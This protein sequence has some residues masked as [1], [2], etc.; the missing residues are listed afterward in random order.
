[1]AQSFVSVWE[2]A[3]ALLS[4]LDVL[5]SFAEAAA[6]APVPYV[7]PE[8]LGPDE[9]VIELRGCR[10]PCVEVQVGGGRGCV[11]K[12][13]RGRGGQGVRVQEM[14]V[15]VWGGGGGGGGEGRGRGGGGVW[16]AV[17]KEAWL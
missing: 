13:G 11:G 1:M 17:H 3:G 8:M 15:C 6:V 14:Q 9:G 16:R 4:E 10:H 2:V 12:G 5:L 7:R